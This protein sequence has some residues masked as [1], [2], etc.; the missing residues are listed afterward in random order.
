[1]FVIRSDSIARLVEATR[2]RDKEVFLS[3]VSR[4]SGETDQLQTLAAFPVI[5]TY[6]DST[7]T[8]S[9]EKKETRGHRKL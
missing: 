5:H 4:K 8:P 2:G 6:I 7:I 1:M 9:Q 3:R